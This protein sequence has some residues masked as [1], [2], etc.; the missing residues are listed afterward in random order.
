M[1]RVGFYSHVDRSFLPARYRTRDD[2]VAIYAERSFPADA[3]LDDAAR[4]KIAAEI[5]DELKEWNFIKE[6]I[7]ADASYTNPAYTWSRRGSSWA[8]QAMQQLA[9]CGIIQIG[10]YGAW[11]FQGMMESFEQG[12]MINETHDI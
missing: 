11:R 8:Q 7:T 6:A 1:H 2:V 10:R 4:A 12:L 3:S 5:I 9:Q